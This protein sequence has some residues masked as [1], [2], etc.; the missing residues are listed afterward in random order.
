MGDRAED[1]L[2]GFLK[3]RHGLL[4]ISALYMMLLFSFHIICRS[5]EK[6]LVGQ[7]KYLFQQWFILLAFPIQVKGLMNKSQTGRKAGAE[8]YGSKLDSLTTESGGRYGRKLQAGFL[9]NSIISSIL[10]G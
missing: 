3:Y 8:S 7:S 9:L 10:S 5:Q 2:S 1:I 6:P 4:D